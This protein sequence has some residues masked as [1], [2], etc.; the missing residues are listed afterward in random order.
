MRILITGG[1][2]F[3][4]GRLAQYL[5]SCGNDIILASRDS[6]TLSVHYSDFVV[7]GIDWDN[8]DELC[9]LCEGVD[10]I[11]HTAGMNA[12]DCNANPVAALQFNGVCT[13]RLVKAATEQRVKA[14]LYLSTAHVYASPLVGNIS[15]KTC[16]GNKHPYATSHRAGED[17]VLWE[18]LSGNIKTAVLRLSNVFGAPVSKDTNCWMLLVNDLCRQA[19][20]TRQIIL[21]TD[22]LQLRDFVSLHEVCR[23]VEY[24]IKCMLEGL[25]QKVINIGSGVS[26]SV[27]E[28]AEFIQKRCKDTLGF[29]PELHKPEPENN[30]PN[31]SLSYR[32]DVLEG[33]GF[34]INS[35]VDEEIDNLLTFCHK[36]FSRE[37]TR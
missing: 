10:I 16:P 5:H 12:G 27:F 18:G 34:I 15:E 4:G 37:V 24:I 33:M 8:Q 29:K 2:G 30:N 36:K 26:H 17:V 23:A 6:G 19:V 35:N 32:S 7:V 13:A 11:I 20:E 25:E 9:K 3:L 14:F 22:G 21:K 28:M 1:S 31:V